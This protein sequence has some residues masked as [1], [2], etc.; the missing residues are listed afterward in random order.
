M[1]VYP[2]VQRPT[3]EFPKVS[4]PLTNFPA[5]LYRFHHTTPPLPLFLRS[6]TNV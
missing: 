4:N 2:T 6:I 3:I 5:P 1:T